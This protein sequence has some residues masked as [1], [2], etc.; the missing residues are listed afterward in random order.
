M[1]VWVADTPAQ[2]QRLVLV[3]KM[4]TMLECATEKQRSFVRFS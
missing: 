2:V 1:T 4:A 3:V